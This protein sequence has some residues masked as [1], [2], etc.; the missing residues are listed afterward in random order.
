M[1]R[2]PAAKAVGGQG[3]RS[4][5]ESEVVH[6]VLTEEAEVAE[7]SVIKCIATAPH[8]VPSTKAT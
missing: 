6:S 2:Q 5:P 7:V 3:V 4:D 8:R 1:P